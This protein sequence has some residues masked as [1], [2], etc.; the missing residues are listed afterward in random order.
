M[1]PLNIGGDADL[2][3]PLNIGGD[4]DL[5]KPLNIGGN[6]DKTDSVINGYL[7]Y[8]S[9]KAARNS[10]TFWLHFITVRSHEHH[11][12]FSHGQLHCFKGGFRGGRTG[13]APPL[14]FFQIRFFYYNIVQVRGLRIW[15]LY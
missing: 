2:M 14:K 7:D 3:K 11:P 9:N 4:A 5:M 13:R 10:E 15:I 8:L 12:I 1:K 6:A